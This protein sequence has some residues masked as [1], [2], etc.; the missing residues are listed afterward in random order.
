ML[1]RRSPS[2]DE[3]RSGRCGRRCSPGRGRCAPVRAPHGGARGRWPPSGPRASARPPPGVCRSPPDCPA[4]P[5]GHQA[6]RRG[7]K[8]SRG[9]PRPDGGPDMFRAAAV[10]LPHPEGGPGCD[11]QGGPRQPA[12]TAAAQRR[13][14]SSS[15]TGMQSA[16]KMVRHR[17]GS[18]VI[19]P[20]ASYTPG[21]AELDITS[22][23]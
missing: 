15:S 13:T 20:S 3:T 22:P 10:V 16:E 7:S 14:G 21:S 5:G 17:P 2:P 19:R 18:S 6:R 9:D 1:P 11:A 23:G 8:S 4:H 12:W